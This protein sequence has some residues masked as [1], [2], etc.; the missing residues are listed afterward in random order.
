MFEITTG[1][2]SLTAKYCKT[3]VEKQLQTTISLTGHILKSLHDF[4]SYLIL[5]FV[6]CMFTPLIFNFLLLKL[7]HN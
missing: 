7:F 5:T 3:I 4:S 6:F 1:Q 2:C